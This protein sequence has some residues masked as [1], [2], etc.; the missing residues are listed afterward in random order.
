MTYRPGRRSGRSRRH[1]V[2]TCVCSSVH[3][4]V[5]RSP[6]RSSDGIVA[7]RAGETLPRD[8]STIRGGRCHCPRALQRL[9]LDRIYA[10]PTDRPTI[11]VHGT[12]AVG[13]D[14]CCHRVI[15]GLS[16]TPLRVVATFTVGRAGRVG[17]WLIGGSH[18]RW[19]THA[20]RTIP[21]DRGA[22]LFVSS[23]RC[24]TAKPAEAAA[25]VAVGGRRPPDRTE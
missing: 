11:R 16:V 19:L 5:R 18:R 9:A 15:G 1:V 6:L 14:S 20:R 2:S 3:L 4:L 25:A 17:G 23:C 10:L 8:A 22:R 7:S 13:E 12:L 24:G 21:F